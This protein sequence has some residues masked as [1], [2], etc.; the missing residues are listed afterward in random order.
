[1]SVHEEKYPFAVDSV[2]MDEKRR[3]RTAVTWAVEFIEGYQDKTIIKQIFEECKI[4]VKR[5]FVNPLDFKTGI[6][7][8]SSRRALS[9]VYN[10]F[11]PKGISV[12]GIVNDSA[13]KYPE[14]FSLE[15]G[16]EEI[17]LG[18]E[19]SIGKSSHKRYEEVKMES[20]NKLRIETRLNSLSGGTTHTTTS[21]LNPS[22]SI[23]QNGRFLFERA[24]CKRRRLLADVKLLIDVA[25][26][27]KTDEICSFLLNYIFEHKNA[28]FDDFV[29]QNLKTIPTKFASMWTF[30]NSLEKTYYDLYCVVN[31][32]KTN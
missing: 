22:D 13:T 11:I 30:G 10:F 1:M 20:N 31:L 2:C 9:T 16:F 15:Y 23:S 4:I 25:G 21:S 3:C 32:H 7:I 24:C 18:S 19:Q 17:F 5:V 8:I 26:P 29:L 12:V 14:H 6:I 28:T 27:N